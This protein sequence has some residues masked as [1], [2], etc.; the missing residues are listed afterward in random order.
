MSNE[1]YKDFL[2]YIFNEYIQPRIHRIGRY[3][4]HPEMWRNKWRALKRAIDVVNYINKHCEDSEDI[5]RTFTLERLRRAVD[6]VEDGVRWN[7]QLAKEVGFLDA[8][9]TYYDEIIGG[10]EAELFPESE[11]ELL[12]DLGFQNPRS[13]I[14]AIVYALK[15]KKKLRSS[16][17]KF[18]VSHSLNNTTTKLSEVKEKFKESD[19]K[20]LEKERLEKS[21]RWFMGLG[22]IGQGAA[23]SIG[24]IALAAGALQFPVSPETQTWGALVSA[25]TGVGMILNGGESFGMNKNV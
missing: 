3:W 5:Y 7:N 14:R 22:Q 6:E 25:S 15:A 21:R 19:T 12:K 11:Y 8:F 16:C 18:S 23:L 13:D 10:L 2:K 20:K 17:N 9:D 24:D 4:D 1:E